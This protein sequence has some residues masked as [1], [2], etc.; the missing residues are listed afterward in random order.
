MAE[1]SKLE[2]LGQ[3][4]MA[5]SVKAEFLDLH[6]VVQALDQAFSD[7]VRF[8]MEEKRRA[9]RLEVQEELLEMEREENGG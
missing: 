5:A 7:L 6:S 9:S 8:A 1:I 4:I 2:E 3:A